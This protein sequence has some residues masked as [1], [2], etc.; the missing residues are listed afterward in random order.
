MPIEASRRGHRFLCTTLPL[1]YPTVQSHYAKVVPGTV[2][3][4]RVGALYGSDIKDSN[5]NRVGMIIGN[6]IKDTYGNRVGYPESGASQIEMAAAGLILFR[7]KPEAASAA[8]PVKTPSSSDSDRN[9]SK[10]EGSAVNSGSSVSSDSTVNSLSQTLGQTLFAN[11]DGETALK[12]AETAREMRQAEYERKRKEVE[13][14]EAREK[15]KKE[16]WKKKRI[17]V[18]GLVG[19]II[20][21]AFTF[22]PMLG[23]DNENLAIIIKVV[24]GI[25]FLIIQYKFTDSLLAGIIGGV[26]LFFILPFL[27]KLIT[28]LPKANIFPILGELIVIF[29]FPIGFI[30]G[31][32]ITL[33]IRKIYSEQ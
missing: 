4:Y 28:I 18:Y 27:G 2:R 29:N 19:L 17:F 20:G 13:E 12:W 33:L 16:A 5:G 1:A 9:S 10:S 6:D 32:L 25:T 30:F 3:P 8:N 31:M 26:I 11:M 21:L 22:L 23:A 15:A 14:A 24:I 7:L